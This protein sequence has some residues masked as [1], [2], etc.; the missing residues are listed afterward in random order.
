MLNEKC[1]FTTKTTNV[2]VVTG[3][4]AHPE[5]NDCITRSRPH[6]AIV[7]C[8]WRPPGAAFL[9]DGAANNLM[10]LHAAP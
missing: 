10:E 8:C 9:V 6:P 1:T 4:R 2:H 7:N 3:A 5:I